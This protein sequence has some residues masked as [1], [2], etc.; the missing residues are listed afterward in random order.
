[1]SEIDDAPVDIRGE[2]PT[3]L[4][5][6]LLLNG[7]ALWELPGGRLEHWF[8]GYGMWHAL[9]VD[10]STVR[11]RS[12]FCASESLRRSR[13]AGAPVFGEFGTAN[14]ASFFTRLKAPQVTDNPS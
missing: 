5:G 7:P 10:G 13:A 9:R 6:T 4:A 14:P 2:L 8:D 12:R 1:A 11:Y 3:W